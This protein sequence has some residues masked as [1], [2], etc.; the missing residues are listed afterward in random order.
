MPSGY[1]SVELIVRLIAQRTQNMRVEFPNTCRCLVEDLLVAFA[2]SNYYGPVQLDF[3][4]RINRGVGP[5]VANYSRLAS[6]ND[7]G[8]LD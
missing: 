7:T 3:G 8:N 5:S 6:R 2:R 4:E 1:R